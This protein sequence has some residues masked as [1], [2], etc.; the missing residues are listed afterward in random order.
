ME[1]ELTEMEEAILDAQDFA[2]GLAVTAR[3]QELIERGEECRAGLLDKEIPR[4]VRVE[5]LKESRLINQQLALVATLRQTTEG[6][7]A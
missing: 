6:I 4:A 3:V 7:E 2:A 1:I 5:A